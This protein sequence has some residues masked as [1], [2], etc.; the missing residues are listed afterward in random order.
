MAC[1]QKT[2]SDEELYAGNNRIAPASYSKAC[3]M[4][5]CDRGWLD[6]DEILFEWVFG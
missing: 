3:V 4:V 2:N 6:H 5:D 1:I